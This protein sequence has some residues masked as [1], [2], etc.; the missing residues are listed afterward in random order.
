MS[1]LNK[2]SSAHSISNQANMSHRA[3]EL[4]PFVEKLPL[5]IESLACYDNFFI[6]GT[7]CGRMLIN[8]VKK[9]TINQGAVEVELKNSIFATK[10][11]I[12]QLEAVKYFDILIAL[13]DAQI[14]VFSL[15]KYQLLYSIAKSKGCTSFA[16]SIS[17]DQKVLRLGVICKKKVQFYYVNILAKNS[18]FKELISDL[19]LYD[20]PKNLKFTKDN[21]VV[22]SLKK[23]YYYYEIPSSSADIGPSTVAKQPETKFGCGTRQIDPLCEKLHNEY[24]AIGVDENKT[25][26]HD[27]HGKPCLEHPI[28][29]SSSPS[30]VSSVGPYLIGLIPASNT[31]EVI[32][33][34]S[35]IDQKTGGFASVSVQVVEL[36]KEP[37]VPS[38]T[39]SSF[40][41]SFLNNA[42]TNTVTSTVSNIAGSLTSSIS[43]NVAA[44]DRLK[45][46]KSNGNC[47]CYVAT[48]S[49]VWCLLPI[50][51]NEQLD[52][53][54]R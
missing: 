17:N 50:K 35:C 23:D 6:I 54:L 49:N 34:Q 48:Q 8:E 46:L 3:F 32:S 43:S 40:T 15:N 27:T 21:L 33:I 51:I 30:A 2:S 28:L 22:F 12:Q 31:I 42:V 39:G 5:Q 29:W 44:A 1:A 9:H 16:T 10:K 14:H 18:Q 24:L 38:V 47:V 25:I 36:N 41:S 26:I 11:P 19:E 4:T 13:F 53:A 37:V 20:V 52:Q 45:I 7:T